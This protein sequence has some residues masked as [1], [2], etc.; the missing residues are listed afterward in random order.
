MTL[1]INYHDNVKLVCTSYG[2]YAN[3]CSVRQIT[4]ELP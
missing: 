4:G 2:E 3:F 1:R